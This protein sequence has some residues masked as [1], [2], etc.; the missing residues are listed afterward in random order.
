MYANLKLDP[1]LKSFMIDSLNMSGLIGS[2]TKIIEMLHYHGDRLIKANGDYLKVDDNNYISYIPKGKL[3]LVQ[4]GFEDN[5]YR[6]QLKVGRLVNRFITREGIEEFKVTAKDVEDFTNLYKNYFDKS[7]T[8][9][10]V[11]QGDD[12]FKYYL[13]D[14]YFSI[15]G[16]TFGP[17]WASC[18]RQKHKN[19]YMSLYASNPDKVK[20]LV[21]LQDDKVRARALLWEKCD[22]MDSEQSVKVMDRIY[23]IYDHD[24]QTFKLWAITSG[25]L[26]KSDQSAHIPRQFVGK[27]GRVNLELSITLE[28][29]KHDTYPYLDTFKYYS[30]FHKRFANTEDLSYEYFLEQ[31]DGTLEAE[32]EDDD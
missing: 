28:N 2:N 8:E 27:G 11:V 17:L 19:K 13:G 4:N 18:M 23:S 6:I 7:K 12:I 25:Y 30:P 10:K 3:S 20:L 9:I 1:S 22:I 24:I 15:G 14:N 32:D 5:K 16:S 29:H 21:M 31:G 26:H